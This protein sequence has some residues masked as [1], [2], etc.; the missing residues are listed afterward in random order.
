MYNSIQVLNLTYFS[1]MRILHLQYC[2]LWRCKKVK[3]LQFAIAADCIKL[4]FD[5]LP[6]NTME[7][8]ST[9]SKYEARFCRIV[10]CQQVRI[11]L[12]IKQFYSRI[13]WST[14]NFPR[15]Y[16]IYYL[17]TLR[18]WLLPTRIDPSFMVPPRLVLQITLD[19]IQLLFYELNQSVRK[20][21]AVD[22]K[23][24]IRIVKKKKSFAS[25]S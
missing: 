9:Y 13:I 14:I 7:G 4:E 22:K 2:I 15:R 16:S 19:R 12:L 10:G 5:R 25:K 8:S 6:T 23:F 17:I 20:F 18:D 1:W 24:K 11:S 3:C 21:L